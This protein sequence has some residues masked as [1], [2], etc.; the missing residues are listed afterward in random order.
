MK[1]IL[2]TIII[3][4]IVTRLFSS[5]AYSDA[6]KLV[7]LNVFVPNTLKAVMSEASDKF[8]SKNDVKIEMNVAGT[9][10]LIT[11]LKNGAKCDLFLSAD[12]RYADELIK[13]GFAT[14]YK[15]FAKTRLCVVSSTD[16]VKVF[17]DISKKGL[18]LCIADEASPIGLFTKQMLDKISK[19]NPNFYKNIEKNI[20]SREF[21]ITDVLS[22]VLSKEVDAGIVYK[23]DALKNQKKLKIISIPDRY[24]FPVYHYIAVLKDSKNKKMANDFLNFLF[25]TDA[26]KIFAKYG[27]E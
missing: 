10:V 18:K 23:T 1:K 16:R 27:Y 25:S 22:K 7:T 12:K 2:K 17:N 21:Q 9:H 6:K 8:S 3:A 20:I 14:S 11:Q 13:D 24:Y 26:K 5:F 4:L 15:Q 19:D